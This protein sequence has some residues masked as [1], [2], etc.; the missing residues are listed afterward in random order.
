MIYLGSD[1]AGFET[2]E[3]VRKY[4]EKKKIS[5]VDFTPLLEKGDD[6]P[7]SA[8]FVA[9]SV[10]KNKGSRGVLVCGSGTG[11]AIAANRVKGVRAALAYDKF[12]AV[13]SRKDNDANVITLRGRG[14]SKTTAVKL[15][16]IWLNTKFSN[17]PRHK[18]RIAKLERIK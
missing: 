10:A 14:F 7:D 18:R 2:K 12:S 17:E 9:N 6:Y 1:H 5:Y 3:A 11:M 13:M 16:D 4:L 8:R 15:V